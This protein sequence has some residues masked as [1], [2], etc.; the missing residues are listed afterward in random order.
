[1]QLEPQIERWSLAY[2]LHLTSF[3]AEVMR[4]W[5]GSRKKQRFVRGHGV[6]VA[7]AEGENIGDGRRCGIAVHDVGDSRVMRPAIPF[8]SVLV[9]LIEQRL[10]EVAGDIGLQ[11]CEN[12]SCDRYTSQ[13]EKVPYCAFWGE[14]S[15]WTFSSIPI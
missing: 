5:N 3:V 11:Q 2:T 13:P 1:M 7:A 9:C 6:E 15:E 8:S 4:G 12:C 10:S 14:A